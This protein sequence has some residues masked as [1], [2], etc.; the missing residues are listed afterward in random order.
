[1]VLLFTVEASPRVTE[2]YVLFSH[3]FAG[4]SLDV[5]KIF[6]CYRHTSI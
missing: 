2:R 1:M 6:F 4:Y 5:N 3:L